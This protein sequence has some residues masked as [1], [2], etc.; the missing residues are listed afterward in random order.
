[1][2]PTLTKTNQYKEAIQEQVSHIAQQCVAM[3]L[4]ALN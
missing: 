1:M 3:H 4:V 2:H